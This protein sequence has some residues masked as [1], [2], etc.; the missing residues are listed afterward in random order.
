MKADTAIVGGRVATESAVLPAT[1]AIS[2][3]RIAAILDPDMRPGAEEAI[4]ARGKIVLPGA[5][6]PHV[7]FNEP[8]RTHWEGFDSG[9]RSAAAGGIT[10]VIEMPLNANPPTTNANAFDL[11]VRTVA[12]KALVDYA[13]WGGLVTDNTQDLEGLER[14]GAVAYKAFMIDSGTEFARAGDGVLWEGMRRI[15][16][17]NGL[18]GVHAESQEIAVGLQG[19]LERA[20]RRDM[21]AWAESRPPLVEIEA[22]QR[23][24]LL[25]RQAG[26]RLHI[27]HVSCAE[28]ASLIAAARSAGQTVSLETCPHYLLL[29][30]EM[31]ARL[32]P[33]AKCAPPLRPRAAVEALWARVL[34]GT[35]DCLAS[36]HAPCPP[37]AKLRGAGNVWDAWGGISGVQTSLPLMVSEGVH[38]RGLTL[39]RLVAL[40]ATNPAKIFRLYPYK[41]TL[42]P[43]ADADIAIL[44]LDR[45][46]TITPESLHYHHRH[47]PF[48]GWNVKGWVDRV[49]VRGRT[50]VRN[51]E[52]VGAPGYG[53][54]LRAVTPDEAGEK[55][56]RS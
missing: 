26:C 47:T 51:G 23:A 36:D 30:E 25:A 2:G 44:D 46:W 40:T 29:D 52:V 42:L 34:D 13:L 54:L 11:K 22:V 48:L 45:E 27:V 39:E 35:V 7:H 19:R 43:G 21:R 12:A 9:T 8:G 33:V 41:G 14:A 6:D 32:G 55:D 31:F 24:L 20:G 3:G 5:I 37:E 1:V 50:V 16:A 4:D 53:R 56:F 18:L 49:L 10:T 38:R 15:A 17:W 28:S